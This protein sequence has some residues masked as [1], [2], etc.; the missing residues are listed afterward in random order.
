MHKVLTGIWL[1]WL[2][3]VWPGGPGA[4]AARPSDTAVHD[5]H[6]AP[7]YDEAQGRMAPAP[8]RAAAG[9]HAAVGAWPAEVK[10][11]LDAGAGDAALPI[12]RVVLQHFDDHLLFLPITS[13][14]Q[15]AQVGAG[16]DTLWSSLRE[17]WAALGQFVRASTAMDQ[18]QH[19]LAGYRERRDR[20][21]EAH[22]LYALGAV[23]YT[24]KWDPMMGDTQHLPE[25]DFR[26]SQARATFE[27]ALALWRALGDRYSEAAT[28]DYLAIVQER[29]EQYPE[30]RATFAALRA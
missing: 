25:W 11:I 10:R 7:G 27:Q 19:A 1:L 30:A 4:A 29:Q 18:L 8:S 16:E 17:T 26:A 6:A 2:L 14:A 22:A 15:H 12:W 20:H 21:G 28:L 3:V 13:L 5:P 9:D 23:Q 24:W